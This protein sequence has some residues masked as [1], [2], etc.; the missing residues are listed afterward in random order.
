MSIDEMKNWTNCV[1]IKVGNVVN[2]ETAQWRLEGVE[3]ERIAMTEICQSDNELALFAAPK[4]D[5]E[6]SVKF[7]STF[8]GNIAVADNPSFGREMMKLIMKC[9]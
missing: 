4:R 6:T 3:E 5:F 7:C 8:G 1:D 9:M 2:W